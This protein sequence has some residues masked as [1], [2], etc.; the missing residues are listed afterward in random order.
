M[1]QKKLPEGG[2]WGSS[3]FDLGCQA[4][5]PWRQGDVVGVAVHGRLL[6][7]AQQGEGFELGR[8]IGAK[9]GVLRDPFGGG[10]Y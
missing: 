1:A 3:G 5:P 4:P 8:R 6:S 10:L 2:W 9:A 7:L